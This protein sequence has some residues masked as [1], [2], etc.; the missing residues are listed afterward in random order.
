MAET[1]ERDGEEGELGE[2]VEIDGQ[3]CERLAVVSR[4][5]CMP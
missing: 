4:E 1:G 5:F 2:A 3:W